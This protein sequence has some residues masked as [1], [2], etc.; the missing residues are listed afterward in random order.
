MQDSFDNDSHPKSHSKHISKFMISYKHAPIK[1]LNGFE[2]AKVHMF[3]SNRWMKRYNSKIIRF[4]YF[5]GQERLLVADPNI[6]R[7]ILV[8]NSRNYARPTVLSM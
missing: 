6:C 7:Q 3:S 2:K 4:Y 5:G 1:W 8:T